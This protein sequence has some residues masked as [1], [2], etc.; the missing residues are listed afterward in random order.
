MDVLS[1][2]RFGRDGNGDRRDVWSIFNVDIM[3]VKGVQCI[4]D[5][6]NTHTHAERTARCARSAA[7]TS[8]DERV[9]DWRA[10]SGLRDATAQNST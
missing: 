2:S 1:C 4:Y 10:D 8:D 5:Q 9:G 7:K 6:V 3:L